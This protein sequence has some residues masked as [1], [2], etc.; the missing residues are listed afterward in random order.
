MIKNLKIFESITD[1][2]KPPVQ[3]YTGPIHQMYID[4]FELT[5]TYK[6]LCTKKDIIVKKGAAF[7]KD[8]NGFGCFEFDEI[9]EG[10][11]KAESNCN[12]VAFGRQETILPILANRIK[13]PTEGT[14]TLNSIKESSVCI[15]FEPSE[16]NYS[17]TVSYK[18][19]KDLLE[20]AKG[21]NKPKNTEKD[22]NKT[23]KK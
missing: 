18:E 5:S 7:Y 12:N 11:K 14:R 16:L 15:Y 20:K 6:T 17:H 1:K 9:L 22:K 8:E 10:K 4:N 19:F 23:K 13:N 21:T 3:I 2:F